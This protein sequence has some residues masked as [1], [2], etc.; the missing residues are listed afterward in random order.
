MRLTHGVSFHLCAD[1][2]SD[3]FQSR[4]SGRD[5]V[6][7]LT[8]IWQGDGCLT[9]S[10]SKALSAFLQ[11]EQARGRV[12]PRQRPGSYAWKALR[13]EVEH[14]GAA[15]ESVLSILVD[16][17]ARHAHDVAD[18]PSERTIRRWYADRR[19]EDDDY[20]TP[21]RP[22]YGRRD[23]AQAARAQ[24]DRAPLVRLRATHAARKAAR[25]SVGRGARAP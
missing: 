4:N 20:R 2:A 1:H 18:A 11:R 3:D 24:R 19:W 12:Q 7:T 13:N 21:L 16:L 22:S 6:L 10:R 25:P 9:S 23:P 15:G 17:R 14:R 5:F 8:R